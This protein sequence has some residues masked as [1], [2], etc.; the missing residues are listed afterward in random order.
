MMSGQ[1]SHGTALRDQF[2][3]ELVARLYVLYP[4]RAQIIAWL[5]AYD[6]FSAH[7]RREMNDAADRLLPSTSGI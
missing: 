3:A 4:Q 7:L 5:S 6:V 1:F 2:F